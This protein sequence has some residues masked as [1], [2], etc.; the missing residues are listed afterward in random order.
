MTHILPTSTALR[1]LGKVNCLSP[2]VINWLIYW[3]AF[4]R[5]DQFLPVGR[6]SGSF[7]N[8]SHRHPHWWWRR[9][10]DG[11]GCEHKPAAS[12]LWSS[13]WSHP[14]YCFVAG[15]NECQTGSDNRWWQIKIKK[16]KKKGGG[17]H[18]RF[19]RE[20]CIFYTLVP[21]TRTVSVHLPLQCPS[22]MLF[23]LEHPCLAK[24]VTL[25]IHFQTFFNIYGQIKSHCDALERAITSL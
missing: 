3:A 25:W 8:V 12:P 15:R 20:V 9:G 7:R 10:F 14:A 24:K 1:R 5:F 18:L 23:I 6:W 13:R 4:W 11:P 19:F 21:N 17:V 22:R 2:L 16:K